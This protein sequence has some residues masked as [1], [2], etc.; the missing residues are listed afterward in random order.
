MKLT[1]EGSVADAISFAVSVAVA[2]VSILDFALF[3]RPAFLLLFSISLFRL[4]PKM[5]SAV[6]LF[7]FS[8]MKLVSDR[9][10]KLFFFVQDI[11]QDKLD[12]FY[13]ELLKATICFLLG[14]SMYLNGATLR[15]GSKAQL[16]MLDLLENLP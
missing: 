7:D 16:Q 10:I 4:A 3:G 1:P 6:I 2:V 15:V 14:Q 11:S 5:S 8:P 12:C 9:V 13:H